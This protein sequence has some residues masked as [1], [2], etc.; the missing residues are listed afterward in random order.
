MKIR[1]LSA[2]AVCA[3]GALILTG[4]DSKVGTAAV[5]DGNKI[6]E[7]NV[8]SYL[9]PNA[10]PLQG[11]DGSSTAPR[12]F[13]LQYLI[14]IKVFEQ[15]LKNAGKPASDDELDAAKATVL[16]GTTEDALVAQV[17]KVGLDASFEK[18]F[19]RSQELKAV[20]QTKL[21][22]DAANA[23][24]L[25]AEKSIKVNPRYG[26]WDAKTI[27]L[28]DLSRSQLPSFLTIDASLPGDT[29]PAQ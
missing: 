11:A 23:A 14:Q 17:A 4:C 22:A 26:A 13:V 1:F 25:P 24:V 2:A 28:T 3:A 12:T 20:I 19:L 9:T 10:T 7:S 8:A 27:S 16:Q 15:M 21:G 5:V 29:P 18:V 6:S